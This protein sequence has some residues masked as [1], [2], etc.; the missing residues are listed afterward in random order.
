MES[1]LQP[2]QLLAKQLNNSIVVYPLTKKTGE[3]LHKEKI[4]EIKLLQNAK[5]T[6]KDDY[7]MLFWEIFNKFF[8]SLST[9][10][11][12]TQIAPRRATR[13][14]TLN[15]KSKQKLEKIKT[16]YNFSKNCYV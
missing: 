13:Q 8:C 9:V 11:R 16:L 3:T 1:C 2:K 10:C 4:V 7:R 15:N 14:K 12:E 6:S 5:K